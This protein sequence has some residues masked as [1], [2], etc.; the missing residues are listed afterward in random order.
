MRFGV[1][2]T[3]AKSSLVC[4][5]PSE[6]EVVVKGRD[7]D[8]D[9]DEDADEDEDEDEDADEDKSVDGDANGITLD[10]IAKFPFDKRKS[11]W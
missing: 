5:N 1:C 6:V 9:E 10:A 4:I 2:V 3:A 7:E 11:L 8:E